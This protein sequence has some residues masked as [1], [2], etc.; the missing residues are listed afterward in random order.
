MDVEAAP[1]WLDDDSMAATLI[2]LFADRY[3]ARSVDIAPEAIRRIIKRDSGVELSDG[4]LDRLMTAAYLIKKPDHFYTFPHDFEFCCRMLNSEGPHPRPK[5]GEFALSHDCV[6]GVLEAHLIHPPEV[7]WSEEVKRY[8]EV[9]LKH[10]GLVDIPPVFSIVGLQLSPNSHEVFGPED[11]DV[12]VAYRHGR[13]MHTKE[14]NDMVVDRL[15]LLAYQLSKLPIKSEGL[16][17]L[18]KKLQKVAG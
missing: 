2:T 10:D 13:E 12:L 14:L 16:T 8:V 5:S 7:P 17:N 15:R 18:V 1:I 11:N 6:W 4:N 3:G 9:T